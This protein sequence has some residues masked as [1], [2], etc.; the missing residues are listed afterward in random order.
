M[1]AITVFSSVDESEGEE[2]RT[3]PACA[4]PAGLVFPKCCLV[5]V[6]ELRSDTQGVPSSRA[7]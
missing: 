3:A 1:L 7:I 2:Q 4:E 6:S 5:L